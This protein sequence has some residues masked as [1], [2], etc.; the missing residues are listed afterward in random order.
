MFKSESPERDSEYQ[1]WDQWIK[2]FDL[3]AGAGERRKNYR[4]QSDEVIGPEKIVFRS[5]RVRSKLT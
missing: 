1:F 3:G 5:L 4:C 2:C